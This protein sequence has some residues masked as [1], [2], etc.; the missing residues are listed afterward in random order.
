MILVEALG[1]KSHKMDVDGIK[2]A[3]DSLNRYFRFFKKA[4]K[5]KHH[6]FGS[7]FE[8]IIVE[9]ETLGGIDALEEC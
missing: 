1:Y 9:F 3:I 4:E 2:I 7:V 8:Q 5:V 6:H